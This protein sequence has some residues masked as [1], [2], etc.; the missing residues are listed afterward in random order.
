MEKK[1]G[2]YLRKDEVVHHLNG[3]KNDNRI[4]NLCMTNNKDHDRLSVRHY[5]EKR[6]AVLEGI[7]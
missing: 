5:M 1:L 4:E 3:K 7:T 2:R 6:I